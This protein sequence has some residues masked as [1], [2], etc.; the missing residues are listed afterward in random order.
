MTNNGNIRS[1]DFRV[2][3]R[4]IFSLWIV[5]NP[6]RYIIMNLPR[7]RLRN[8]TGLATCITIGILSLF[9]LLSPE[10]SS[11]AAKV[12]VSAIMGIFVLLIIFF[13]LRRVRLMK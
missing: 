1:K 2:I 12:V 11:A 7:S 10:T 6:L 8:I 9:F 13:L 3:E 4:L 5:P